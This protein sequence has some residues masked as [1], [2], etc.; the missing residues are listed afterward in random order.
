MA[1]APC[2]PASDAWPA[3]VDDQVAPA[4]VD[5][6]TPPP[7]VPAYTIELFPGSVARLV[8]RPPTLP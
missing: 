6:H 5:F 3:L 4:S 1:D 7:A 8:T 2:A